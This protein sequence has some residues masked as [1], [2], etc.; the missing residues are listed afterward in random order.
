MVVSV[1]ALIVAMGGTGYAALTLPKNS[2][3][4]AT[5]KNGQVKKADIAK[6]AVDTTRVK[7]ASLL[8]AD[9]APG[10]LPAGATGP[11]GDK[12][13]KGET[14]ATGATGPTGPST[15]AAGG[16]LS[17]SYP[18]PA[19]AADVNK[20]VPVAVFNMT[21]AGAITKEGHRAPVTGAVTASRSSTGLYYVTM[22]GESYFYL[23][24][25]A[26]CNSTTAGAIVE[27]G[28]AGGELALLVSDASGTSIDADLACSVYE[29]G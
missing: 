11:K 16:V 18:N 8:A 21:S 22:P 25:V 28:S 10:Q 13:D 12:G 3:K 20:V 23:S 17:G 19:F 2:V 27:V 7:D 14:G 5:I 4:S 15:G 9:F 26:N 24:D 29:L 6:N 1:I